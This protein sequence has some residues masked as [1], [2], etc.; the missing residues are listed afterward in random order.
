MKENQ[1][2][3][4][5]IFLKTELRSPL[6]PQI[7]QQL[8]SRTWSIYTSICSWCIRKSTNDNINKQQFLSCCFRIF[9]NKMY[10]QLCFK[11]P[12]FTLPVYVLKGR[13]PKSDPSAFNKICPQTSFIQGSVQV[14]LLSSVIRVNSVI[15]LKI[16]TENVW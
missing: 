3:L 16:I 12:K 1:N 2:N 13:C 8:F 7:I 11:C 15:H 10:F 14:V 6:S 4:L 5:V 9:C